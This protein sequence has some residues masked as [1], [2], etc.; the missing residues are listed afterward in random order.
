[1]ELANPAARRLL[2]VIP[3]KNGQDAAPAWQAPEALRQPLKEALEDQKDYLPESFDRALLL[4]AGGR[5]RA[6]L[7]RI[8]AIRD[9]DG[10]SLGAAVLLQDVTR[11]RL[12]DQVK[13]NLVAT[14]SHEFKTPL[15]GLRLAL[16]LLL[17][18]TIG[19]LTPKQTELLIDARENSERLL[20]VV[21]NMLDLTRLEQGAPQLTVAPQRLARSFRR[22]RRSCGRAR[23]TKALKSCWMCLT[24]CR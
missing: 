21:N 1:M 16:Y 14:A 2:G 17:E 4:G 19:P 5:E 23:P 22:R 8:M 15:T 18:E 24:I 12:L 11:M 13:S 6:F 3:R 7:P 20:A 9:A 10:F